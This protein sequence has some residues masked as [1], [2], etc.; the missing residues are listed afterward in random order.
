MLRLKCQ[1][2]IHEIRVSNIKTRRS[3]D[4]RF[5]HECESRVDKTKCESYQ[6]CILFINMRVAF[7]N[8]T[9][10]C[11][12]RIDCSTSKEVQR[13]NSSCSTMMKAILPEI[14]ASCEERH[15]LGLEQW[16]HRM[17]K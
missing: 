12:I 14:A 9:R 7:T 6:T 11:E 3:S 10:A 15:P 16:W 8:Q 5:I 4:P 1:S 17:E 13:R 2:Q